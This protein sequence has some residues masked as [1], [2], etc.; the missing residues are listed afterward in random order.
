VAGTARGFLTELLAIAC[1]VKFAHDVRTNHMPGINFSKYH[2][3]ILLIMLR[4]RAH[5]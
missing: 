5:T 4:C 2:T 1:S 3:S